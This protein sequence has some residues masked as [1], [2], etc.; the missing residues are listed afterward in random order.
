MNEYSINGFG[1]MMAD[2]ERMRAYTEA[3]RRSIRPDS[4]VIDIGTGTGILALIA[5]RLGARRVYAIEPGDAIQVARACAADNGYAE[6]IEFFQAQSFDVE[7]PERADVI[8]SDLRGVLPP[9]RRHFDTIS[10]ARRRWLKPDGILIPQRDRLWAAAVTAPELY[11]DYVAPWSGNGFG[12]SLDRARRMAVNAP[13]K[14]IVQPEQLLTE[15]RCWAELDYRGIEDADVSGSVEWIAEAPGTGHGLV[16]WFD[17]ELIPG[18]SFSNAPGGRE[19]IYGNL[20]LPWEE[21]VSLSPGDPIDVALQARQVDGDY[22]WRWN[23]RVSTPSGELKAN[24]S[25]STFFGVPL[26][27]ARLRSLSG[28]PPLAPGKHDSEGERSTSAERLPRS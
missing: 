9:H 26:S 28:Q 7:L 22:I 24:F 17:T 18:V 10:D 5:C 13:R 2:T 25:Q 16:L 20:F 6:R 14:A 19:L 3:L 8:V 21:P 27:G 1:R 11:A 15:P 23:T 12:L 4:V